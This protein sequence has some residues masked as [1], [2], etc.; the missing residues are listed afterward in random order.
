MAQSSKIQIILNILFDTLP[1]QPC[2]RHSRQA[3]RRH[4]TMIQTLN[5]LDLAFNCPPKTTSLA[6]HYIILTTHVIRVD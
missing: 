1:R 3:T 6:T 4:P 5:G 2:E